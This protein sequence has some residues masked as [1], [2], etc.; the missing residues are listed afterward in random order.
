MDQPVDEKRL[1][2]K[3]KTPDNVNFTATPK[4]FNSNLYGRIP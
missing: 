3:L 4:G 1:I 2:T